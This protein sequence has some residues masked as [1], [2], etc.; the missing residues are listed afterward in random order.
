MAVVSYNTLPGWNPIRTIR[1]MMRFH[2][3]NFETNE[4]KMVQARSVL[5][6][7]SEI[8]KNEDTPYA[9]VIKNELGFLKNQKDSYVFHDHLETV[10]QPFYFKDIVDQ[11]TINQVHYLFD[12]NINLS[13]LGN[14]PQAAQEKLAPLT[15]DHNRL[16]QYMDF[17]RGTRFRTSIFTK[18]PQKRTI[19]TEGIKQCFINTVN[20]NIKDKNINQA[21]IIDPAYNLQAET[22]NGINIATQDIA[23]KALIFILNNKKGYPVH[24]DQL[25]AQAVELI[26]NVISTDN[27][28]QQFADQL[29]VLFLRNVVTLSCEKPFGPEQV[30]AQPTVADFVQYQAKDN[31]RRS[32]STTKYN[33]LVPNFIERHAIQ[34]LDGQHDQTQVV[35]KNL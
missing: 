35:E 3:Q 18:T 23:L 5:Q 11:A 16:E 14:M 17:L 12:A 10:S 33:E 8:L 9:N 13:F 26:G 30:P 15:R 21:S 28:T 20:I 2:A 4:E 22:I 25:Q 1:D 24:F 19:S 27:I 32:V 31:S 6:F 34:Y 7:A 29:L